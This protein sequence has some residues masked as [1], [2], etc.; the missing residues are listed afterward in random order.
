MS[1]KIPVGGKKCSKLVSSIHDKQNYVFRIYTFKQALIHGLILKKVDRV[2]QFNQKAWL[3][4]YI[5]MNAELRKEAKN[6]F[7][8]DFF[9]LMKNA[10]F[11]KPMESIRKQGNMKLVR[12][13]KRRNQLASEPNYHTAKH[14]SENLMAI[15]MKKARVKMNKPGDLDMS[16]LGISKTLM[17]EFGMITLN[18]STKTKQNYVTWILTASLFILKLEISTKTLPMMFK[19]CLTRLYYSKD[20]DRSLPRGKN[21]KGLDS[22]KDEIGGKIMTESAGLGAKTWAYLIHDDNEKKNAKQT[23]MV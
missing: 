3:K 20:Y 1:Q 17:Y 22:F 8:K 13:D 11:R 23:K 2:V 4:P 21:K 5:D 14:F 6:D 10:V 12:T 7:E 18:Q 9:K 16:I 19:N 15:K